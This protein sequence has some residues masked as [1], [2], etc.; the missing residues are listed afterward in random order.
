ML[1]DWGVSVDNTV[2]YESLVAH[3]TIA[4]A[5]SA[6]FNEGQLIHHMLRVKWDVRY[7]SRLFAICHGSGAGCGTNR[8]FSPMKHASQKA[9]QADCRLHIVYWSKLHIA[10]ENPHK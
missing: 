3:G 10:H 6:D 2:W 5:G 4:R 1:S 9:Q 8:R 7:R